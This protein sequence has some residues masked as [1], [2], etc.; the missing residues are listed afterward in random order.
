MAKRKKR[1]RKAQ[2]LKPWYWVI[3][4]LTGAALALGLCVSA[5]DGSGALP[6]WDAIYDILGLAAQPLPAK[7]LDPGAN[8]VHFIDVGQADATLL[9]SGGEYC[10]VDAGDTDGEQALL[11]YLQ[12]RGI[13]HLKLLVMSHPHADHIG[14][15]AAV[16]QNLQ[17]DQV[18]LPDFDKA[19]YPTTGIFENVMQTILDRGIPTVTAEPGQAYPIGNGA[20]TVIDTGVETENYN[21]LSQT[22]YFEAGGL[23]ALLSGDGEKPVEQAALGSGRLP[24]AQVFKAAHHGSNTSNTEEF[25]WAVHPRYVVISC[26]LDNSYGHP[27]K[28]PLERFS[29]LGAQVL[30]TDRDGSVVIAETAEGLQSYA[31]NAPLKNSDAQEA[32]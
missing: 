28:E 25:L 20:L 29:A 18:L 19:P 15:M 10:L 11:G 6:S 27:H 4:A 24:A 22:L 13:T 8:A 31:A 16:L 26:G 23:T 1:R 9:Q 2:A 12:S 21:D 17:V 7:E 30:R 3:F 32:A 14:S 5:L